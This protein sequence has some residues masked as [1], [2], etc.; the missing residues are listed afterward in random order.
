MG[1][2]SDIGDHHIKINDDEAK[3]QLEKFAMEISDHKRSLDTFVMESTNPAVNS[4]IIGLCYE[5]GN[6][7]VILDEADSV[8]GK[9]VHSHIRDVVIRGRNQ[10]V[11]LI[12]STL[13]P[14][15]LNIDVRNQADVIYSFALTAKGTLKSVCDEFGNDEIFQEIKDLEGHEY[16]KLDVA[17][18]NIQKFGKVS[19]KAKK[20]T[21]KKAKKKVKYTKEKKSA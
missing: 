5:A 8:F 19:H 18:G 21:K 16:I 4:A 7:T 6:T 17:T 10:G 12:L 15:R 3:Y 9:T 1:N 14:H 20:K 2:F 13:R 11:D